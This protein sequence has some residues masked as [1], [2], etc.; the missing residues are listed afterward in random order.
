MFI[1]TPTYH[2][3]IR[4][5]TVAFGTLF[6]NISIQR[7]DSDGT[8]LKQIKVPLAY[9][10]KE[11]WLR[12]INEAASIDDNTDVRM[13]LP[14]MS[15]ELTDLS[16][17][18]ER[19][20]NPL[21]KL[22]SGSPNGSSDYSTLE[23]SMPYDFTYELSI[24]TKFMDDGLQCIE[25]ILPYFT[26]KFNISTNDIPELG[27][28][29]DIPII[30]EDINKE[31]SYEGDF[32]TLREIIWTLS[33]K[34]KGYLYKPAIETVGLI[35]QVFVDVYDYDG[36]TCDTT[37]GASRLDVT[38]TPADADQEDSTGYLVIKSDFPLSDRT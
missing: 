30:L 9:G 4:R 20:L 22:Y 25:Q 21:N 3:S 12:R 2:K 33:F 36:V 26:P 14:R 11:K 5:Y 8:A 32:E 27:V 17:A 34:L 7:F 18:T 23:E 28:V 1:N 37:G 10:P 6:N 38:P 35:E 13:T 19:M 15:F 31:D 16:P 29:S 24:M